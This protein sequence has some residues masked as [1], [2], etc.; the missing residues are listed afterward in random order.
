LLPP[1]RFRFTR[2]GGPALTGAAPSAF[3]T[4]GFRFEVADVGAGAGG[5]FGAVRELLACAPRFGRG[6]ILRV[7]TPCP[8]VQR[9]VVSQ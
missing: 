2:R 3:G 9:F 7:T 4:P 1:L 5:S 6:I 8:V